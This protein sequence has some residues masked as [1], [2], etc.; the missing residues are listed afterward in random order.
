[1]EKT[2]LDSV[3]RLAALRPG[4]AQLHE[5]CVAVQEAEDV[6]CEDKQRAVDYLVGELQRGCSPERSDVLMTLLY[7]ITDV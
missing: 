5:F 2:L 6:P 3:V 7:A 1:M 4:D